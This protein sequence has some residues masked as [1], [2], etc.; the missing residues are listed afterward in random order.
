MGRWPRRLI[1]TLAGLFD[2]RG[3]LLQ[4]GLAAEL[5]GRLAHR[6]ATVRRR[7]MGRLWVLNVSPNLYRSVVNKWIAEEPRIVLYKRSRLSKIA[8]EAG[9]VARVE[10]T[11]RDGVFS[12]RPGAVVDAT[13]TAEVVRRIAPGLLQKDASRCGPD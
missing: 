5:V 8:C 11:G 10:V 7:R 3:E 6:H 9:K 2:S 4:Q 12:L 1:H 13:G